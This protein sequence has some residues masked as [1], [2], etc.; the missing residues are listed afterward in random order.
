MEPFLKERGKSMEI[1]L[2]IDKNG[3]FYPAGFQT[4]DWLENLV[5]EMVKFAKEYDHY[6]YCDCCVYDNVDTIR[7][8]LIDGKAEM[9][10]NSLEDILEE[11]EDGMLRDQGVILETSLEVLLGE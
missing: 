10:I 5:I 1:V 6:N 4:T 3:E 7:K 2:P 9:Y 11:L 8:N